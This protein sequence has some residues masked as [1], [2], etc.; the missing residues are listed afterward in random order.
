MRGWVTDDE[1]R[2]RNDIRFDHVVMRR[3]YV[4]MVAHDFQLHVLENGSPEIT[5]SRLTGPDAIVRQLLRT[6]RRSHHIE[7]RSGACRIPGHIEL[8]EYDVRFLAGDL[9]VADTV[10]FRFHQTGKAAKV[11]TSG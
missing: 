9:S 7:I 3:G 11:G 1:P 4:G 6:G 5:M 8:I 10:S 2:T